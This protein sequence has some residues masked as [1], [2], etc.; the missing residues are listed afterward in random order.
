[1]AFEILKTTESNVSKFKEIYEQDRFK[2]R[3]FCF[4]H[5]PYETIL[6]LNTVGP[7]NFQ[8]FKSVKKY[9]VSKTMKLYARKSDVVKYIVSSKGY[10]K[11]ER[12]R[13]FPIC[14]SNLEQDILKIFIEKFSWIRFLIENNLNNVLFNTIKRYKL[15]SRDKVLRHTYGCKP[16]IA[17]L[18][19]NHFSMRDW[20]SIKNSII[21]IDNFNTELFNYAG[22]LH[23]TAILAF[24]MN[25][26]VNASWSVRRLGEQ[27]DKWSK[28]FTDIIL[29]L[30]NRPLQ[31]H[32]IFKRLNEV[33]GGG[34]ITTTKDLAIEGQAQKHCVASYSYVIESGKVGIFHIDGYTAEIRLNYKSLE[35]H[36]LKG[37]RNS[38]P[39]VEY[40][41]LLKDRINLFNRQNQPDFDLPFIRVKP[42]LEDNILQLPF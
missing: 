3:L 27:H 36:Q 42:D 2:A 30:S 26:K 7:E 20:K 18:I 31:I 14:V 10:Y 21:N 32:P 41:T 23:D 19:M 12:G 15:Y 8:I 4:E 11:I 35:L 6:S 33:L 16:D 5:T 34:L 38:E 9:G 39:S 37:I 22:K 29:E 24:K 40:K 13:L 1:M 17:L 28:D 25:E